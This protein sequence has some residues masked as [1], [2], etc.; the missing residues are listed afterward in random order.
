MAAAI[1]HLLEMA[2]DEEERN[3]S[4][5]RNDFINNI[6]TPSSITPITTAGRIQTIDIL[7]GLALLG[8]II[9]NFTA[10]SSGLSPIAG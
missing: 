1:I 6:M 3:N 4:N 7:R 2:T 10:D 9:I 5:C 8:I